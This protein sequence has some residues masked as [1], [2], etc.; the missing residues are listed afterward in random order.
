MG[1]HKFLLPDI[2]NYENIPVIEILVNE[3]DTVEK[4]QSVL[5]LESDKATMEIPA[6]VAGVIR[7]I[8]VKLEEKVSAGS[9]ICDIETSMDAPAPAPAPAAK[10]E[11]PAAPAPAA[12]AP[13][14]APA[15]APAPAMAAPATA[16]EKPVNAQ[17]AG[18]KFH[19]SPSVRSYARHLGVELAQVSG[20]GPKG[21][22]QRQDVEAYIKAV[23]QGEKA[24][25][26]APVTAGAGIPQVPTIDFS[27][28]GPTEEKELS[29]IKKLSG[30]HLTACWLNIP[31][32]TQF[33]ETDITELEAFRASLKQRAD[34]AGV[35]L[36]PLPFVMMALVQALKEFPQF[37]ASLNPGGEKLIL[38]RYYNIGVAVD[39]PNG[40]VVPVV[41]DADRKGLFELARELGELG[42]KARDG[43]LSP[44]DMQGGTF[45]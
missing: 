42:Q 32:I 31:H 36:T 21:R 38:K 19:A 44:S 24:A 23:M 41:K 30:K 45:S 20:T 39:T 40:L 17:P 12:E 43:K 25:P 4:D 10:A 1:M 29:R 28:F 35:K 11:A 3:G 6:P 22:I 18:A 15:A 13:K 16:T 7:N 33:D 26:K 37:N 8:Q 2:G 9:Y 5:T 27:Q 34:K 14:P